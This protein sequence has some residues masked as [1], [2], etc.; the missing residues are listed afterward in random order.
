MAMPD[1]TSGAPVAESTALQGQPAW[2]IS[3]GRAGNIAQLRGVA[4]ALGVTAREIVVSPR[5][6]WKLM[7]PWGPVAPSENIGRPDSDLS[8]PWPSIAL[9]TGRASIPYIRAVKKLAGA[10]TYTVVLQDPRSGP[11]TADM[12]WVPA[13][14]LRR[15]DNVFTTLTSPHVYSTARLAELRADLPDDI[16]AL[17]SP[18][19][20]VSLGG[21]NKVYKYTDA[22]H[23]RLASGLKSLADLGASFM[24]TASRR[25]HDA[26]VTAAKNATANAPRIFWEGNGENPYP[27]FLASADVLFVTGDSVNMCGEACATGKPVVVFQPSGGSKKF[28]RFHKGLETQAA[29]QPMPETFTAIPDWTYRPLH[30]AQRIAAEIERR[31]ADFH[32]ATSRPASA[33]TQ[34]EA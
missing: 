20:L 9:A 22:D 14:D 7:A 5:G 21:R 17:P 8:P 1:D 15:G 23:A 2:L 26:L 29:V 12:I 32:P 6:I 34:A 13:H 25:S 24:M 10:Q 28:D 31:Y 33:A 4:K 16:R 3:D 18:R 30:S 11:A 19:V 27:R